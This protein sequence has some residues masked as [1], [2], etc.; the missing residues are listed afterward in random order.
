MERKPAVAFAKGRNQTEN[1]CFTYGC[2][3][4]NLLAG[5]SVHLIND[6]KKTELGVFRI[7]ELE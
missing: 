3:R 2:S 7:A 5:F 1:T 4:T 6:L